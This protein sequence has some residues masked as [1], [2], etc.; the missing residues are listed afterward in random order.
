[1]FELPTPHHQE[2]EYPQMEEV[3]PPTTDTDL[4]RSNA[5]LPTL[6]NILFLLV[7]VVTCSLVFSTGIV[8]FEFE[9]PSYGMLG[10]NHLRS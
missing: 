10:L 5:K 4:E 2:V 8:G 9:Y 3:E 6:L 7:I 1:M